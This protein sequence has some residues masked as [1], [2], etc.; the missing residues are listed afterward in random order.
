ME[1]APLRASNDETKWPRSAV[2]FVAPELLHAH[3]VTEAGTLIWGSTCLVMPWRT[4]ALVNLV[5]IF[6]RREHQHV[7]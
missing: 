7:Y 3:F 2:G 5:F 4:S 1:H 6:F